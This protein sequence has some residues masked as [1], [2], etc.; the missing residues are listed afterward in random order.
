MSYHIY[1]HKYHNIYTGRIIFKI[2]F[3]LTQIPCRVRVYLSLFST[4]DTYENKH[5][6]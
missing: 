5:E 6:P 3:K 2:V 4:H 1:K